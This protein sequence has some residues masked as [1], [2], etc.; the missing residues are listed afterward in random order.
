M[1]TDMVALRGWFDKFI[2]TNE[3][4]QWWSEL[5][6]Y[7]GLDFAGEVRTVLNAVR[8]YE[9]PVK[10]RDDIDLTPLSD[11][12]GGIDAFYLSIY[13]PFDEFAVGWKRP[14]LSVFLDWKELTE[15]RGATG[16]EAAWAILEAII[17][18]WDGLIETRQRVSPPF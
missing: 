9:A 16:T 12:D 1:A 11:G 10:L 14:Y 7:E 6:G 8:E 5:D 17:P 15:D 13:M 18:V 3:D 2:A 4:G